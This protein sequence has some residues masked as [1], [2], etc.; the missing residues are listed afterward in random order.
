[1]L[2][3]RV[4]YVAKTRG[5]VVSPSVR[6]RHNGDIPILGGANIYL[7][8]IVSF[9]IYMVLFRE[10]I[11]L[12]FFIAMIFGLTILF[13]V[14][15][16]DDLMEIKPL[17]KIITQ[18]FVAIIALL[19]TNHYNIDFSN[20]FGVNILSSYIGFG[21][22]IFIIISFI[23]AFNFIDGID[24][25]CV[26]ISLIA[27]IYF[28]VIAVLEHNTTQILINFSFIGALIPTM[29]CNVF[30]KK[31]MFLGDNGAFI[32]GFA[33]ALQSIELLTNQNH[34]AL[35]T[36]KYMPIII[37]SLLSYPLVD[38]LRVI[39]IRLKRGKSPL[40]ADTNHIHHHLSRLGLSHLQSTALIMV[41]T[42]LITTSACILWPFNIN[43]SF[44]FFFSIAII[45][46]N[47]PVFILKMKMKKRKRKSLSQINYL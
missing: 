17:K 38:S 42:I 18:L 44:I 31:K 29:Y 37:M 15:L 16:I 35:L 21:L 8:L 12:S 28:G 40:T 10:Y 43:Y 33:L 11:N 39:L 2:L 47:I 23:N 14:G 1:V 32:L 34:S 5:F 36:S 20:L 41:Y 45:M 27:F 24:G 7:S 13:F 9:S 46:L 3:P 22:S 30:S 4:Y 26:G 6:R 25:L 19:L